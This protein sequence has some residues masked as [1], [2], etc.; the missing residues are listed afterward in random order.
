MI[1]PAIRTLLDTIFRAPDVPPPPDVAKMRAWAL[2]SQRLLGGQPEA[3]GS[4]RETTAPGSAGP[5]PLR[6]YRSGAP[7]NR[8]TVLYAHGGGWVTGSL[9]S[10]D[11]LC[12]SLVNR[13][14]ATLVAVDYR[15]APEHAYPAALD[16]FDAAWRWLQA[17]ASAHG[18][19]ASC[20]AVAGDSSGA[21]LAAGLTHRL[22]AR[23]DTQ[24]ALQILLYPALDATCASASYREFSTGH[25]LSH[26][27]MAWYW[28]RYVGAA[29]RDDAQ[30]SP[31]AAAD[32]GGLAPA[33][34][35][36][37]E[38]DVLRDDGLVYAQRLADSG[39]PVELIRCAG[40]IHGFLRWTG[41]V[42]AAR[43]WLDAIA[44]AARAQT[45]RNAM[46]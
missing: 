15:L 16:D 46:C 25:N 19:D 4:V 26:K 34:V 11:T 45:A 41:A 10:H 14:A 31:I 6:V 37:A 2:E 29:S 22:R 8:M 35:A 39:V 9:D 23:G 30:L 7:V 32:L 18:I 43:T 42:P 40:M 13:L 1:D 5:I 44:T 27:Q 17:D 24:P 21:N 12:R 38:G 3:V 36:V 28:D 33:V 20:V